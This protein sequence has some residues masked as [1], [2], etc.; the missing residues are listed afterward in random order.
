MSFNCKSFPHI[1]FAMFL[2]DCNR[3]EVSETDSLYFEHLKLHADKL[4]CTDTN[5]RLTYIM[6]LT[7]TSILKHIYVPKK[8]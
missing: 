1:L 3:R 4:Y 6:A 5:N 7:N 2:T 8:F